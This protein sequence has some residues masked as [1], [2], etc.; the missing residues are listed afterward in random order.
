LP[1]LLGGRPPWHVEL[2]G[3]ARLGR[4]RLPCEGDDADRWQLAPSVRVDIAAT[5]DERRAWSSWLPAAIDTLVPLT[6]RA[7]VRW[8]D[9]R[10]LQDQQLDGGWVLEGAPAPHLGDDAITGVARFPER[11]V[12]LGATGADTGTRLL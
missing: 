8:L 4:M 3:G 2:D 11:G 5:A 12:R 9:A 1:A 7:R 10:S 6:T